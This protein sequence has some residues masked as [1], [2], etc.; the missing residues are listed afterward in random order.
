MDFPDKFSIYLDMFAYAKPY[1]CCEICASNHFLGVL[2]IIYN[3][4]ACWKL[5][6]AKTC[7]QIDRRSTCSQTSFREWSMTAKVNLLIIT[8]YLYP[9]L[10]VTR[11]SST[12][13]TLCY[14]VVFFLCAC[15]FSFCFCFVFIFSCLF[16]RNSYNFVF[17]NFANFGSNQNHKVWGNGIMFRARR[18][19]PV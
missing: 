3:M 4:Q 1:F 14:Y 18:Q 7:F 16:L 11:K 6:W 12:P 17:Y 8:W 15:V 9:M 5:A 10:S 19:T 13:R 2:F